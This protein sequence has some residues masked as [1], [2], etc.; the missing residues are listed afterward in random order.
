MLLNANTFSLQDIKIEAILNAQLYSINFM[1][2]GTWWVAVH[3]VANSQ[4]QL[5]D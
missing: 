4:T 3:R 2:K 5:S 1:D